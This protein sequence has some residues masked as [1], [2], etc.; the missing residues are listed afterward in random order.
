VETSQFQAVP[1]TSLVYEV[2]I[3]TLPKDVITLEVDFY[4][5]EINDGKTSYSEKVG[6]ATLHIVNEEWISGSIM[7]YVTY[8]I[9]KNLVENARP[10]GSLRAA[11]SCVKSSRLNM[12]GTL[13]Y[14]YHFEIF[15]PFRKRGLTKP[16]MELL[17]KTLAE[18]IEVNYVLLQAYPAEKHPIEEIPK[19]QKRLEKIYS[20]AG[21]SILKTSIPFYGTDHL[22]LTHMYCDLKKK[23]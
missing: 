17:L 18:E 2:N 13:A 16:F 19:I 23:H 10:L 12:K 14:L 20:Q 22:P 11:V 9:N 1:S 7:D 15:Y 5:K 4:Q 21:F 6:K 3:T 8:S